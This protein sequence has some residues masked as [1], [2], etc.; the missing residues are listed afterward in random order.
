MFSQTT[1]NTQAKIEQAIKNKN[2]R[3]GKFI[4]RKEKN[5]SYLNSLN[6]A[7]SFV[8][9]FGK[10]TET[11]DNNFKMVLEYRD[12]FIEAWQEWYL[13]KIVCVPKPLS[14]EQIENGRQKFQAKY[15]ETS[16][17]DEINGEINEAEEVIDV[18]DIPF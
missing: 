16:Q 1:N 7:I 3:I 10:K 13:D 5:I 2:E 9:S 12:K 4:D 8:S 6:S 15:D 18:K 14:D 17:L 11:L